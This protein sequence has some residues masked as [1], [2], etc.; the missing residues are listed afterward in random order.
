VLHLKDFSVLS[1]TLQSSDLLKAIEIAI[2]ATVIEE[3]IAATKA[4]EQRNRSLPAQLVVC[5]IIAMS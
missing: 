4:S 2:P 3:V 1:P 5:L